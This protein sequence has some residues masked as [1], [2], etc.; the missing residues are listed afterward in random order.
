[1]GTLRLREV[2]SLAEKGFKPVCGLWFLTRVPCASL[3]PLPPS[4]VSSMLLCTGGETKA[5]RKGSGVRTRPPLP[6]LPACHPKRNSTQR[7]ARQ[8]GRDQLHS[9]ESS[10]SASPSVQRKGKQEALCKERPGPWGTGASPRVPSWPL[11]KSPFNNK[12][13]QAQDPLPTPR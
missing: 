3:H 5:Q 4:G 2:M 6:G 8:K 10:G 9:T 1:M 7:H 12:T 13:G 11:R